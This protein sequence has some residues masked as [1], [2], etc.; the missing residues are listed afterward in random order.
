[1]ESAAQ[2]YVSLRTGVR[3]AYVEQGDPGGQPVIF[4]H[5][6]TDSWR[7]FERVLPLLPSSIRAFAI[8]QRGH[9]DSSRPDAG[10]RFSDFAGDLVAFLDAMGL[11]TATVVG[12]SMGSGVAL[13]FAVE[14]ADRLSG[15][16][17]MGA[18]ASFQDA[19]LEEFYR[20]SV[21]P[22]ADPIDPGFAREWQVS[23]IARPMAED[24]LDTVVVETL[25]VPARVW[26]QAFAGFLV[27]PDFVPSLNRVTVPTLIAW[28]DQDSYTGREAQDRLV[29]AIPQ[30]RL[31][32]YEG[33]GHAFHWEDPATF[34]ADLQALLAGAAA[35]PRPGS[36]AA[37]RE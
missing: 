25:K 22:L 11:R 29:A 3:L 35:P 5:G 20:T 31:R 6:V 13:Q 34:T 33:G 17:L 16:V 24:H 23:T 9:G 4:L 36:R 26:Q 27:T 28:G 12:H 14:H 8:S 21:A 2:R 10:Y 32:V 30:A 15:L 18:F 1:M 19:G 7:A 37:G